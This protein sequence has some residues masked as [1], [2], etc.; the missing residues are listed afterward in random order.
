MRKFIVNVNGVDYNVEVRE[1][2]AVLPTKIIQ[3]AVQPKVVAAPQIASAPVQAPVATPVVASTAAADGFG[4]NAPMP[5]KIVKVTVTAGQAVKQGDVVIILEA[6]KMQ[7]EIKTPVDGVIKAINVE[8]GQT[9]K[10]GETMVV[11]G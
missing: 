1:E 6:M 4:V 11:I 3:S 9:V 2:N 7:N 8:P 10:P 5:G